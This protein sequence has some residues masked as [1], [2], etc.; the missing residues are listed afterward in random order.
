MSGISASDLGVHRACIY[1][2]WVKQIDLAPLGVTS[3]H[4]IDSLDCMKRWRSGAKLQPMRRRVTVPVVAVYNGG[5]EAVG[6]RQHFRHGCRINNLERV[7]ART[8]G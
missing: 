3:A 6:R 1:V 4:R 7:D 5:G 8:P 2:V